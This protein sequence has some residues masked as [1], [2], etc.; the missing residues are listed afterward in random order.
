MN[1]YFDMFSKKDGHLVATGETKDV[2]PKTWEIMT[3][4]EQHE[5]LKEKFGFE[6]IYRMRRKV[7]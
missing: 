5:A 1:Y 6:F 2:F 4:S 7:S 3:R